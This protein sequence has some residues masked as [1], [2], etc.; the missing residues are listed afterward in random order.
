MLD[1]IGYPDAKYID[2][3]IEG[4]WVTGPVAPSHVWDAEPDPN[5]RQAKNTVAYVLA[6]AWDYRAKVEGMTIDEYS[7][8]IRKDQS[9]ARL[10]DRRV[11]TPEK[12]GNTDLGRGRRPKRR[13]QQTK[14]NP[15]LNNKPHRH[16]F[17]R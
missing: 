2:E 6:Q 11:E 4:L 10:D 3:I 15:R 12:V 16:S 17:V 5:K 8:Q 14:L 9:V 13:R 1:S 7:D